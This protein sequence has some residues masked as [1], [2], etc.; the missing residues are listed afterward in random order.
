MIGAVQWITHVTGGPGNHD[1]PHDV[2]VIADSAE[3]MD[4]ATQTNGNTLGSD[5]TRFFLDVQDAET[6]MIRRTPALR[7]AVT[8]VVREDDGMT[9]TQKLTVGHQHMVIDAM[10]R[11]RG[12]HIRR[13]DRRRSEEPVL[14]GY[15]S[16]GG[17]AWEQQAWCYNKRGYFDPYKALKPPRTSLRRPIN[18]TGIP[19][20]WAFNEV[21]PCRPA[22]LSLQKA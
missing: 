1:P 5:D 17:L 6:Q 20:A 22:E 16:S 9:V 18:P 2:T 10:G 7:T 8:T 11:K 3:G 21:M 19:M 14:G 13:K 12:H 4:T 15:G